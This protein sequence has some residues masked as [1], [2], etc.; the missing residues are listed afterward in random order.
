MAE[1]WEWEE[2]YI[3]FQTAVM[4]E[5][6]AGKKIRTVE[7]A[8]VPSTISNCLAAPPVLKIPP[9]PPP[10]STIDLIGTMEHLEEG[11]GPMCPLLFC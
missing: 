5:S 10:P 4:D 9:L 7:D 6:T 1:L 2:V 11:P 3:R 8:C